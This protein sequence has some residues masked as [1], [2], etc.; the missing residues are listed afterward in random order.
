MISVLLVLFTIMTTINISIYKNTIKEAD[1]KLD[2]IRINT[3]TDLDRV[4][5][6]SFN[7]LF[8]IPY[9]IGQLRR[10][11][12]SSDFYVIFYSDGRDP[13]AVVSERYKYSMPEDRAVLL[14][15]SAKKTGNLRGS[16]KGCRYKKNK[17]SSLT[18]FF[19]IDY[20]RQ[21]NSFHKT[22]KA[23]IAVSF[24]GILAVFM[25]III[26]SDWI[27]R[28]VSESYEKQKRF[29]T[30]AGH[31]L[32]TPL[33][34]IDADVTVIEME[35]GENEWLND[36]KT[37]TQRLAGLTNE[38]VYL[39]RMDEQYRTTVMIDFPLS[40]SVQETADS[41]QSR[42]VVE[43]KN[44]SCSITPGLSYCG[45][46]KAI[47]RLVSI[48]LDNA[49]KYSEKNGTI[50]F[51]LYPKR[52][53]VQ[54]TIFNTT[55]SMPKE[56]LKYLFDRFYRTDKSRNSETGGYGIGLSIAQAIVNAHK[57]KITAETEDE[58]SLTIQITL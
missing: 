58:K 43:E 54:F 34:T 48:L 24:V 35:S 20:N 17:I 30:D 8:D 26:F 1:D 52:K 41:F 10:A 23:C 29:I 22:L 47:R 27:M 45:D 36:I 51:D 32:K 42:A 5:N 44:F 9:E 50:S 55:P 19:F 14:A 15:E 31:E 56:S 38:L 2:L 18:V 7:K 40:D 53:G 13:K 16:I 39:A 21:L 6:D 57:G 11:N 12:D 46:E 25:L 28:P 33:A 3:V 4:I 37:Q 49:L